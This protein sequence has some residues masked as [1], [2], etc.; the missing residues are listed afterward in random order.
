MISKTF[1]V[2]RPRKDLCIFA[3]LLASLIMPATSVAQS[4]GLC[5]SLERQEGY[6]PFDYRSGERSAVH[7]LGI[8]ERHH[9]NADVQ[10]LRRGQTSNLIGHDLNYVL[11][12][13]PNHHT[14]LDAMSRLAV[15]EGMPQPRGARY[16]LECYF[17]RAIRFA[18]EDPAVRLIQG[19]HFQRLGRNQQARAALMEAVIMEPEH[20]EV[21][22]NLGLALFRLG[23][24]EAAREQ[25]EKAYAAG[26]P[27]PGLRDML[28]RAGHPLRQ[29]TP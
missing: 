19:L 3:L 27:L 7:H 20:A 23:D 21:S 1:P 22:Y 24:Y 26:Y 14:A 12:W 2:L 28:R 4:A 15:R 5:G 10:N 9:F 11:M 6:G 13:F 25:A 29:S 18:P 16:T 8:V 17:D